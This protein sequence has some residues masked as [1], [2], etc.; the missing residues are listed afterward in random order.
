MSL[1][2]SGMTVTRATASFTAT[3][4]AL[5]APAAP[6]AAA[7]VAASIRDMRILDFSVFLLIV[8]KVSDRSR[9]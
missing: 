2:A 8:D 5:A 4:A 3:E 6:S 7:A 9:L 1:R